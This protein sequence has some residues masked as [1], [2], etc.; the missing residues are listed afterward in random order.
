M[1]RLIA[2]ASLLAQQQIDD[3]AAADVRNGAAAVREDV[4]VV[5][6]GFFEV[7]EVFDVPAAFLARLRS[8]LV[9]GIGVGAHFGR[10]NAQSQ[11]G[12]RLK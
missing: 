10:K 5:A 11:R 3:P 9:S 12:G 4:D 8:R 1:L 7:G 6:A 2:T